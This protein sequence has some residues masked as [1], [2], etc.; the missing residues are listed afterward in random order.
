MHAFSSQHNLDTVYQLYQISLK[1]FYNNRKCSWRSVLSN[2]ANWVGGWPTGWLEITVFRQAIFQILKVQQIWSW[3][4]ACR[5]ARVGGWCPLPSFQKSVA[6][7]M[8]EHGLQDSL[9]PVWTSLCFYFITVHHSV[10][11]Y[12]LQQ[13][14]DVNATA[15]LKHYICLK[16]TR[17]SVP[18]R[19][20]NLACRKTR[21]QV[22]QSGSLFGRVSIMK[23]PVFPAKA[24]LTKRK[25][26]QKT[27]EHTATDQ[28]MNT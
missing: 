19:H 13:K 25:A 12:P 15:I 16:S 14:G 18:W 6:V 9:S 23:P 24:I 11:R 1:W 3:N 10:L 4:F 17:S 8:D 2:W 7:F 21:Y 5:Y 26:I 22:L 27:R 20:M 28:V